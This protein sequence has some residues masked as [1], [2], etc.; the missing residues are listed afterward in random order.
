ML[1]QQWAT[2]CAVRMLMAQIYTGSDVLLV[3]QTLGC[4]QIRMPDP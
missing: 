1:S 4:S 2:F 3:C